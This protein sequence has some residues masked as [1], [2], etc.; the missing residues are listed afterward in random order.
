MA[1]A[2]ET[3]N[4]GAIAEGAVERISEAGEASAEGISALAGDTTNG[5]AIVEVAIERTFK[6]AE[7]EGAIK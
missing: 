5:I 4:G 2:G 6:I 7:L 1:H 3:T